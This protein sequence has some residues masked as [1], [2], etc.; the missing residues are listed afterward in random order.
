MGD[1]SS[2]CGAMRGGAPGAQCARPR[3]STRIRSLIVGLEDL[4]KR[5]CNDLETRDT[6]RAASR[7]LAGHE[8]PSEMQRQPGIAPTAADRQLRGG[9]GAASRGVLAAPRPLLRPRALR[10]AV[11]P[12][13]SSKSSRS[14]CRLAAPAPSQCSS[15]AGGAGG[16][17]AALVAVARRAMAGAAALALSASCLLAAGT[18]DGRHGYIE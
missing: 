18:G 1:P 3:H 10:A 14:P 4:P 16:R 12:R 7:H 8:K 5:L 6:P 15:S 2:R 11:G 9:G 17:S 13:P